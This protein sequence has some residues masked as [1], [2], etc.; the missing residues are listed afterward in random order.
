MKGYNVNHFLGLGLVFIFSFLTTSL[1]SAAP[2]TTSSNSVSYT[3]V[4]NV[5]TKKT[6]VSVECWSAGTVFF[7]RE[8]VNWAT[9]QTDRNGWI[10][11]YDPKTSK[12]VLVSRDSCV[13]S[14]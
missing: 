13:I 1:L 4:G 3:A 6:T 12:L 5:N 14:F 9:T 2:E 11:L 7:K 10:S 8:G